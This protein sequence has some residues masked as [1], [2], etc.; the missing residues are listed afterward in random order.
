MNWNAKI[1]LFPIVA[2]LL[3]VLIVA[4]CAKKQSENLS[5]EYD[6]SQ[7]PREKTLYI[8]GFQWGAPSSFNPLAITP[9]WPITGNINLIYQALFGYD[10]LSGEIKPVIGKSYKLKG[11]IL[12]I[13]VHESARWQNGEPLTS[14]DVVYSYNLHK[15]YNTN[16]SFGINNFIEEIKENGDNAVTILLSEKQYNPLVAYDIISTVQILPKKIFEQLE[17]EAFEQVASE[18]GAT[19]ENSDILSTM[20]LFKNDNHPVG[21][22]PYTLYSYTDQKIILRRIQSYWGNQL[23]QD[24][25]PAPLFI[26]HSSYPG[27]DEVNLALQTGELDISQTFLPQIWKQFPNGVGTWYN[28][29][30]YYIPGIIPALM[31]GLSRPP[32]QDVNFRRAIIHAIDYENIRHN[33]VYGYTPEL[34]PGIILPFGAEKVFFSERDANE[35]GKLYDPQKARLILKKAGYSWGADGMLLD[36]SAKKIRTLFATCPAGWTDWESTIKIVVSCLRAIGV[37]VQEK[38]LSYEQW[39]RD[40]KNGMFDFT[41]KNPHPEQSFSLPWARFDKVMSSKDLR[42]VGEVMYQNEGRYKNPVA[43][44]L[45]E[46]IPRLSDP[47]Q[48]KTA[49]HA[50]NRLFMN[51]VPVIPLM[52]RPWLFYQFNTKYWKNFPTADNPYASPQCL[53]VGAGVD[54]LWGISSQ[55]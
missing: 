36:P 9:A 12:Q 5:E 7:L 23:F 40:L 41:M 55:K 38:F 47:E 35:F 37:D 3:S 49:Y 33:A 4:G 52:Y 14:A 24:K 45:L 2:F 42:P 17:K 6:P 18:T 1:I 19:P 48:L 22:G 26:V 30:P 13:E 32:I 31:M 27:N 50:I 44:S 8:S 16:F 39:D 29:K 54:A 43:D 53:M 46:L 34:K 51:E 15:K 20:R 21:S 10:L 28:D 25:Q 11:R